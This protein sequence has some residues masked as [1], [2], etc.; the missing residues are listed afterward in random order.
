MEDSFAK[1]EIQSPLIDRVLSGKPLTP[2]DIESIHQ[3]CGSSKS[4]YSNVLAENSTAF[5]K[6]FEPFGPKEVPFIVS[7]VENQQISDQLLETCTSQLS[8]S[9]LVMFYLSLFLALTLRFPV[10]IATHVPLL[11]SFLSS[12]DENIYSL[13]VVT[14]MLYAKLDPE[15]TATQT[16]HYL[17]EIL[18]KKPEN[19]T[20]REYESVFS[21][22]TAF[23]PLFPVQMKELYIGEH[24]KNALLHQV[25]LLTPESILTDPHMA[26]SL[27]KVVSL[28]CIDEGARKFNT[29]TYLP[30]LIAGTEI[31][32]PEV[33]ALSI[34]CVVKL[35]NF[36]LIEKHISLSSVLEKLQLALREGDFKATHMKFLLEALA[37]LSLSGSA[38][39]AIR[40]DEEL[41][42]Q[43]IL[44]LETD[45]DSASIYGLLLIFSNLSKVK[46]PGTDKDTSTLN[47]LKS[48]SL[49]GGDK[50]EDDTEAAIGEF[51]IAL[52]A[53]H[54]FIGTLAGL[55]V[56]KANIFRL[57]VLIIYNISL[58]HDRDF[59]RQIVLQ[60][61]LT[62]VLKYLT[63]FSTVRKG[64]EKTQ[65]VS[66]N[67]DELDTRLKAIRSLA[68]I[69]RTVDPKLAFVSF[70]VNTAVP[71][72]VELLGP[73]I[74]ENKP[75]EAPKAD[76]ATSF[77]EKI[78]SLDKYCA[79]L[80]LTNLCS[81]PDKG[82]N[83]SI[84]RKSFDQHLKDS[85]IDSTVPDIQKATWELI[86]NLIVEPQMLAKFFNSE[87][88]ESR[89][90]LDVLVK[91]LHSR[92]EKLQI[93]LAGLLANATMEFELVP[94][95]L[96]SDDKIFKQV[97]QITADILENQA[98]NDDLVLRV[99]TFLLNLIEVADSNLS[100]AL[101]AFQNDRGLKTGL[102]QVLQTTKTSDVLLTIKEIVQIGKIKF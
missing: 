97:L 44:F 47:Y 91:M 90:H 52:V 87:N 22:F 25:S 19:I 94:V 38:K 45:H 40:A 50:S 55:E 102:L 99:V 67:D 81:Y 9:H 93:V 54:R 92:D 15:G 12:D 56:S 80:A 74:V 73:E 78:T 96:M 10:G 26:Q 95:V 1:L 85:M 7:L 33:S 2:K 6:A 77:A 61:G 35:W 60:G 14:I 51:N 31:S 30:F 64:T 71:F 21:T 16:V 41:I 13:V 37:Y 49:P 79:L 68:T 23:F 98:E 88:P 28:S 59:Q 11:F 86:N 5:L 70:D 84:I 82:L 29:E 36:S 17:N 100:S 101:A 34:L 48:V 75:M 24:C 46:G 72:L 3:E 57:V 65:G 89:R 27:L 66:T 83:Q 76:P 42:E 20:S 62:L 53:T 63:G 69:S 43:L 8:K 18:K 32:M 39:R 4:A 58:N